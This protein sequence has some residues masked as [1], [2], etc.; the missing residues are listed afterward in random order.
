MDYDFVTARNVLQQAA[1]IDRNTATAYAQRASKAMLAKI[2]AASPDEAAR[3]AMK[4][5]PPSELVDAPP[6]EVQTKKVNKREARL[7]TE[8]SPASKMG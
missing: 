7:D 2:A 1:N 5:L 3:L 4:L 8:D 6:E